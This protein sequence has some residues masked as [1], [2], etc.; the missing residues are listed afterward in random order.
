MNLASHFVDALSR[1][2]DLEHHMAG[3]YDSP[4]HQTMI[5]NVTEAK[6]VP[7]LSTMLLLGT[8]LFDL[9]WYGGK[10]ENSLKFYYSVGCKAESVMTPLFLCHIMQFVP[11]MPCK[12]KKINATLKGRSHVNT[13]REDWSGTEGQIHQ[14]ARIC[15][16]S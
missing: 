16:A 5:F 12:T 10:H 3:N 1:A 7:G 6:F 4:L 8:G 15:C 9:A 2:E 11:E 13:G 14:Y